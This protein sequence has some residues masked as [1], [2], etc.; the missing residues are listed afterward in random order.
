MRHLAGSSIVF[1]MCLT[2]SGSV[3]AGDDNALRTMVAV[4]FGSVEDAGYGAKGTFSGGWEFDEI[5]SLE[6]QGGIGVTEEIDLGPEYFYHF[7][8]LVPASMTICSTE[9]W[10]CPRSTFELVI[11]S[12]VGAARFTERWSPTLVGGVALDSF[13]FFDPIEIGIRIGFIGYY[14]VIKYERLVVMLQL[15]LGVVFRFNTG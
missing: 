10:V 11:I 9:S 12:G 14:D 7:E 4:A 3:S 8:L 1:F 5:I 13:R 2:L 6:V 15:N